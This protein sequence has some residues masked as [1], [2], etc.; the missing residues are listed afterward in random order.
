MS[1]GQARAVRVKIYAQLFNDHRVMRNA[2]Y[3]LFVTD[4]DSAIGAS[5]S[6][7]IVWAPLSATALSCAMPRP[8]LRQCYY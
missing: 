8:L 6:L 2:R 1:L 4:A 5:H 7:I 3:R